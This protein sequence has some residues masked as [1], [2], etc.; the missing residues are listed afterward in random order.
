MKRFAAICLM[1]V[2]HMAAAFDVS[3]PDGAE[4]L[5][6]YTVDDG[7][8]H[9]PTGVFSQAAVPF[10]TIAGRVVQRTW[11]VAGF[12]DRV[13]A[14]ARS[15]EEQLVAEG[16][17]I[18]LSCEADVCGGFDFRFGVDVLPPPD[19]YVDLADFRFV[20]AQREGV[21]GL[22]AVGRHGQPHGACRDG[23]GQR[24]DPG[25]AGGA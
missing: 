20:A 13:T 22:E 17:E 7:Q 16:Y 6:A 14:I 5:A 11:R 21:D 18:V 19:M 23:A 8:Y 1:L 12:S 24:S 3:L 10:E 25:G 9:L 4:P 2:P 15:L